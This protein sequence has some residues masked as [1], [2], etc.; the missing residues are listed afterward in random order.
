MIMSFEE[1][2]WCGM[3]LVATPT[4]AVGCDPATIGFADPVGICQPDD[5]GVSFRES[6]WM[7]NHPETHDESS[8]HG[9]FLSN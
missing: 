5:A 3:P 6:R 8:Y 1:P 4:D 2:L 9:E 7:K